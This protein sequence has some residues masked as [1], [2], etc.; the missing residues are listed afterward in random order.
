MAG[1]GEVGADAEGGGFED[2]VE[3]SV[4]VHAWYE[5]EEKAAESLTETLK[6]MVGKGWS[7]EEKERMEGGLLDNFRGGSKYAVYGD[8]GKVGFEMIAWT[9][10]GRKY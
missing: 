9:G 5:S 6:L 10:V 8:G 4:V 2:V 7:E 3:S 1:A